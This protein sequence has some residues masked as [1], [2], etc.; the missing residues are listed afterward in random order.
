VPDGARALEIGMQL[1]NIGDF[2]DDATKEEK[3]LILHLLFEAI[4]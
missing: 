2:F 1:E 4:Y 3:N